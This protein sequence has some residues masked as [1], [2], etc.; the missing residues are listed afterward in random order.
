ML[1]NVIGSRSVRATS[2]M[3]GGRA[4]RQRQV[5]LLLRIAI[6]S[7][8][9]HVADDADHF[10]LA[11]RILDDQAERAAIRKIPP[12]H[13]LVDH[14][15]A[16]RPLR[17]ALVEEAAREQLDL[18]RLEVA[19]RDD[20]DVGE[21]IF[22]RRRLLSFDVERQRAG[23]ADVVQRHRRHR[24]GVGHA[25]RRGAAARSR[26]RRSAPAFAR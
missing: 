16:R 26:P 9:V 22:G 24:G 13:R 8:V 2:A 23:G 3:P 6:E 18:H 25:G 10:A 21:R 19:G 14:A 7:L 17:I 1:A 5:D 11:V 15:G 12:R 20:A 4:L